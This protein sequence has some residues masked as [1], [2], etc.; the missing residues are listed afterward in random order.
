MP[1]STMCIVYKCVLSDVWINLFLTLSAFPLFHLL[2][3]KW[4]FS[5]LLL[6]SLQQTEP[7]SSRANTSLKNNRWSACFTNTSGEFSVSGWWANLQQVLLITLSMLEST[8]HVEWPFYLF[9]LVEVYLTIIQSNCFGMS[10]A[11]ILGSV[12]SV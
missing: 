2:W 7:E 1:P 9:P 4:K 10:E 8:E 6:Y 5:L 12:H 11:Y 3:Q